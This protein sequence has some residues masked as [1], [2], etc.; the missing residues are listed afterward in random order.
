[1]IRP[2]WLVLLALAACGGPPPPPAAPSAATRVTAGPA[3]CRVGPDGGR[4]VADRGI[5][6]TGAPNVQTAD[7]GIGGTGII[8]VITGFA[9]VCVAGE[10]V[11]LPPNLPATIDGQPGSVDDLRAGQVIAM[12]AAGPADSLLAREI[13]VR[14]VVIGPVQSTGDRGAGGR[15][16]ASGRG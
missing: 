9:S 12:Q 7:R 2:A 15:R 13:V 16:P 5:G 8:G 10:E 4:P 11:A 1:M 3:V 6:G 14:H